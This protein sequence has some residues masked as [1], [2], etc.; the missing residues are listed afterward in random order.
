MDDFCQRISHFKLRLLG[1]G[2]SVLNSLSIRGMSTNLR[3]RYKSRRMGLQL[4]RKAVGSVAGDR[5]K[6]ERGK[7]P[8]TAC[9]N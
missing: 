5:N 4:L 7:S 1:V 8:N 9:V 6:K 2:C 3:V